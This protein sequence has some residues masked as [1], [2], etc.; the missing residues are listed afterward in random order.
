M[1]DR[2]G[3]SSVNYHPHA[4]GAIQTLMSSI[5]LTD[6]W[7]LKNPPKIRYTWRRKKE[8]SRIDYFLISFTLCSKTFMTDISEHMRSDHSLITLQ[9]MTDYF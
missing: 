8:A 7:R 2:T 5:D 6:I 3:N 1:M 9:V 4:H